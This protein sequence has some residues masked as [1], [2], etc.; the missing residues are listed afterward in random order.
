MGESA[1]SSGSRWSTVLSARWVVALGAALGLTALGL[2]PLMDDLA[3]TL[4]VEHWLGLAPDVPAYYASATD[5]LGL[6]NPFRIYPGGADNAAI[7]SLSA[8]PWWASEDLRLV[9]WRPLSSLLMA[10]DIRVFGRA[11]WGPHL[12]SVLWYV[13]L[14]SIL[15]RVLRRALSGRAAL[16]A[17]LIFAIDDAHW[18]TVS[19][20]SN[21]NALTA[22]ALGCAGLLAHMRWRED[23]WRPGALLSAVGLGLGLAAGE[24]G[25]GALGLVAAYEAFGRTD[26]PKRRMLALIPSVTVGLAWAAAYVAGGYGSSGSGLYLDPLGDPGTFA[27]AAWG[28][29]VVLVGALLG[30]VTADAW[31][32]SEQAVWPLVAQ[33]VGALVGTALL[34]RAAWP[35]VSVQARSGVL[36][37]AAGSAAALIPM[38]AGPPSD[39][40]LLLP[41]V[42]A[43]AAIGVTLDVPWTAW[44]GASGH[45][46][47]TWAVRGLA[48]IHLA[49]APLLWLGH[50]VL[51]TFAAA[52]Q[53]QVV[54]DLPLDPSTL[55]DQRIIVLA[56]SDP[57]ANI[58]ALD[59]L[60]YAG[61]PAPRSFSVLSTAPLDHRLVR[62]DEARFSL[63]TVGGAMHRSMMEQLYRPISDPLVP[64]DRVV[65]AP[66]SVEVL[67]GD[68]QGP[69][70]ILVTLATAPEGVETVFLTWQGGRLER[71]ALPPPGESMDLPWEPGPSGM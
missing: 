2:A 15:A 58:F 14:I 21:R 4:M 60:L 46:A 45:R 29:A 42:G 25:L 62:T 12:H 61:L 10:A 49:L 59:A 56:A 20:I 17:L 11:V 37:L 69:T 70:R 41:S 36:W 1:R 50:S 3:Q 28:R 24:A 55:P 31:A 66:L 43:A 47:R 35:H 5:A 33:G 9:T 53:Q 39:R 22:A 40:M 52:A 6:V 48:G 57:M 54:D 65:I 63:S 16:L 13:A 38:L 18:W 34:V 67:E 26:A 8:I 30:P 68:A 23:G 71:V 7:D 51:F 64:G 27:R 19:W 32:L 44:S